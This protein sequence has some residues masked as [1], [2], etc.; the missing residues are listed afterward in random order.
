[1]KALF[2]T[3][4]LFKSPTTRRAMLWAVCASLCLMLSG[5]AVGAQTADDHGNTAET[6]TALALG[7]S[8]KGRIDPGF[9]RDYFRLDLSGQ[10]GETDVWLYTT[11]DLDS[12][13][14]LLDSEGEIL[15]LNDDSYITGRRTSSNIRATVEPGEYYVVVRGY[16]LA[17]VG[18]YTLHSE[19]VEKPGVS[20]TTATVLSLDT[21]IA[22]RIDS[23]DDADHFRFFVKSQTNLVIYAIGLAQRDGNFELL[24]VAPLDATVTDSE[25]NELDLNIYAWTLRTPTGRHWFGFQI[26]D[27][28]ERGHYYIKVTSPGDE[29]LENPAPYTMHMYQDVEYDEFLEDCEAAGLRSDKPG[30]DDTLYACQWHLSNDERGGY[31]RGGRVGGGGSWRGCERG[32]GGQRTGSQSR[33]PA[34]QRGHFSKS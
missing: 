26:E 32:G 7:G 19:A 8:V 16:L 22:G 29:E 13:L 9:D 11:G 2:M 17:E 23:S 4:T 1:M 34:G 5:G 20:T 12:L 33:G 24:P 25:G 10:S 14:F 18:E 31:Q 30:I 28:L 27:D 21:P 6:A 3:P 15:L